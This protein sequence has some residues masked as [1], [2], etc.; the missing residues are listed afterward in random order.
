VTAGDRG[1]VLDVLARFAHAIDGRDWEL[2]RAVLTEDIDVDYASYRP[3]SVGRMPADDWVAR[4][5]KLM[6]GLDATQHLLVNAWVQ[7]DGKTAQVRSSMRADHFLDGARYT[8]GGHYVH[9]LVRADGAWR[10]SAV[11]L[12]VN[13][14]E[15]DKALLAAAALRAAG[16]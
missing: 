15:G 13:W 9:G 4:V 7:L 3:G 1:A 5:G 14:E 11:T 10:I 16:S 12:V 6:P 2:L 8:L